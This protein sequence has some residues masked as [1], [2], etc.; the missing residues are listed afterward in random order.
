MNL[1]P[2]LQTLMNPLNRLAMVAEQSAMLTQEIHSV[3]TLDLRVAANDTVRELK[4]HTGLLGEIKDLLKEQN[5]QLE[6][7]SSG[8]GSAPDSAGFKPMSAK[9]TGLTAVMIIGIAAALV[10]AAAIFIFNPDL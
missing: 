1:N 7:G 4:K 2:L 10:G 5:R 8:K 9:D 3:V 6:T